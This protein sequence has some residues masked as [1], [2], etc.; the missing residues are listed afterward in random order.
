MQQT[1][2]TVSFCPRTSLGQLFCELVYRCLDLSL[3]FLYKKIFQI[4]IFLLK[5]L[6]F[7]YLF[8]Y[9]KWQPLQTN[10]WKNSQ[11][12]SLAGLCSRVCKSQ[13]GWATKRCSSSTMSTELRKW[14]Q[15]YLYFFPQPAER[16]LAP[17]SLSLCSESCVSAEASPLIYLIPP[18]KGSFSG[19]SG[20]SCI[21][22]FLLAKLTFSSLQHKDQKTY[23]P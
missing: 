4:C 16:L 15:K 22:L 18:L 19:W 21:N 20:L 7:I 8:Y 17:L 23:K 2:A 1:A 5:Y 10:H 9:W 11:D 14:T 3:C 13:T 12:R 6:C